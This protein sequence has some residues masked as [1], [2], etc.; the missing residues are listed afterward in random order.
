VVCDLGPDRL[1]VGET[2][3]KLLEVG[4]TTPKLLEVGENTLKNTKS[5]YLYSVTII[6]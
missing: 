6:T 2:A 3:P 4:E 5:N 1:E